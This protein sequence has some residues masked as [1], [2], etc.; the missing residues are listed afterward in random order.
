MGLKMLSSSPHPRDQFIT[1]E[2]EAHLYTVDGKKLTSV[3]TL[4]HKYF[5][6]FNASAVVD[7]MMGSPGWPRSKYYG[8]TKEEIIGLW[9]RQGKESRDLGTEMHAQIEDFFLRGQTTGPGHIPRNTTGNTT[10]TREHSIAEGIPGGED[11]TGPTPG[12]TT[13]AEDIPG[14]EDPE[15]ATSPEF[16][17]FLDFW[18]DFSRLNPSFSPYRVEWRVYGDE[19]AGSI[20]F[21]IKGPNGEIAIIDW[22]R[23]KEIKK[24][25]RFQR[26]KGILSHLQDCN[27]VHYSLQLNCYR[28]ILE[29]YYGKKVTGMYLAV[30]HPGQKKYQCLE[31]PRMKE[32]DILIS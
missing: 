13:E 32:G 24:E 1:F 11:H 4:V 18:E 5:P 14:G 26:G 19:V 3:T 28:A 23:S 30:F 10:E 22:K 15:T 9:D 6:E 20:D 12:N 16:K 8:M 27:F 31:V 7:K 25:N 21:T 2:E 17:Q 29:K